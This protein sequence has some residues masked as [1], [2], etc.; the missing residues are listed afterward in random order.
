MRTNPDVAFLGPVIATIYRAG[1][2][3]TFVG[4]QA[5]DWNCTANNCTAKWGGLPQLANLT[6]HLEQLAIDIE[7]ILPEKDWSGVANIDWEAWNRAAN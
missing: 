2:F 1:N 4:Q 5:P 3:P 7:A 6:A